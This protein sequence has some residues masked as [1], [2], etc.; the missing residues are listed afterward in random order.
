MRTNKRDDYLAPVCQIA[1]M[2]EATYLMDT[3]FPSQHRPGH[4]GGAIMDTSFPSQHRSANHGGTISS[5]K[6]SMSWEEDEEE[7]DENPSWED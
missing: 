4:Y 5:A 2:S 6:A 1:Q 7:N 3:S